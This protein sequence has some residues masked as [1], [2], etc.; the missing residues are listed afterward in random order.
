MLLL[1]PRFRGIV[2]ARHTGDVDALRRAT[3]A[4]GDDD[5]V[6]HAILALVDNP[7]RAHA[8]VRSGVEEALS[9]TWDTLDRS[10]TG[11]E[12]GTRGEMVLSPYAASL[13]SCRTS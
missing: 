7:P 3:R 6:E 8:L 4:D 12:T 9:G 13:C 1:V 5:R 10:D 2:C 11:V